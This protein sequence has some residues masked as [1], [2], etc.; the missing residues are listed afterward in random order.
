MSQCLLCD[1]VEGVEKRLVVPH[2]RDPDSKLTAKPLCGRCFEQF[3]WKPC[4]THKK[5]KRF[6][7]PGYG[8]R[9]VN[10]RVIARPEQIEVIGLIIKMRHQ[11]CKLQEIADH[12]N[13]IGA[14]TARGGYW[15]PTTVHN[16]YRRE[17]P[18]AAPS[19]IR[20]GWTAAADGTACREPDEQRVIAWMVE[21]YR[22]GSTMSA[23]AAELNTHKVPSK[24]GGTWSPV[25]VGNVLKREG[26]A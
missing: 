23:I 4:V 18:G 13:D 1:T 24:R 26:V 19:K 16:I 2:H 8:Y 6:S 5:K 12:L 10:G 15:Q 11:G 14:P 17:F 9:V 3:H 25:T 7:N 20:Y 22:E 21:A